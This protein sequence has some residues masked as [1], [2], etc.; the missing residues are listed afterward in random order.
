MKINSNILSKLFHTNKKEINNF[1]SH[2]LK[3]N[4]NFYFIKGDE[5]DKVLLDI[6]KR[7]RSDDQIIAGKGRTKKWHNGWAE[8]LNLYESSNSLIPKFNP[9]F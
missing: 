9:F 7:I 1:C 5:R 4:L 3:K 8:A 2:L 6:L